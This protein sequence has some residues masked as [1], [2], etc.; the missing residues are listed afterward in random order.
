MSVSDAWSKG[1]VVRDAYNELFDF[2][3]RGP[4]VVE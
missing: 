1:K 3:S 2:T 4:S